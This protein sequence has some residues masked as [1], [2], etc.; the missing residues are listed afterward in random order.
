MK[1][2]RGDPGMNPINI[3]NLA[4][5]PLT[6]AAME[7]GWITTFRCRGLILL[8]DLPSR[9]QINEFRGYL[10][11]EFVNGVIFICREALVKILTLK[12]KL[13]KNSFHI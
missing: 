10:L 12:S 8:Q 11:T 7:F 6:P 5:S 9:I 3:G 2:E 13:G 1:V 4:F